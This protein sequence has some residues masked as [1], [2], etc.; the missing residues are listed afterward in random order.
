MFFK[1]K[2]HLTRYFVY[3]AETICYF[4]SLLKEP[5]VDYNFVRKS[6]GQ[7]VKDTQSIYGINNDY[8]DD[9]D[10][11]QDFDQIRQY[12]SFSYPKILF[13][14]DQNFHVTSFTDEINGKRFTQHLETYI[15]RL[16]DEK[17]YKIINHK[18][19]DILELAC[20]VIDIQNIINVSLN[21]KDE[22]SNEDL[23][24]IENIIF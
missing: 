12:A 7:I 6:L 4:C 5:V 22:P 1:P 15:E 20:Y 13:K 23:T 24:Y 14:P 16:I 21:V 9:Q 18:E 3:S 8:Y 11:D 2:M 19:N 10:F 17:D